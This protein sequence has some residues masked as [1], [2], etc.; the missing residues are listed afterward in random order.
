MGFLFVVL[1]FFEGSRGS[2]G[3][4]VV[5]VASGFYFAHYGYVVL[6]VN[7]PV[8]NPLGEK[9]YQ[10][11]EDAIA[12]LLFCHRCCGS[13]SN[14]AHKASHTGSRCSLHVAGEQGE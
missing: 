13:L 3:E 4:L 6:A 14:I 7:P 5:D 8:G 1:Y 12:D 11:T 10:K 2:S 9:V